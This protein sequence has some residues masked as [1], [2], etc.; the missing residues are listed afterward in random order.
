MA[1]QLGAK[2]VLCLIL[3]CLVL[4]PSVS[5]I[6]EYLEVP[7][8]S[9]PIARDSPE[10]IAA[11]KNHIAYI[12]GSQEA[13]M[14]GV[15]AY[16]ETISGSA[17]IGNLRQIESDYMAAASTIPAMKTADQI[18]S[19][20][21]EMCVQSGHFAEESKARLLLFN[22]SSDE[23]QKHIA[24]SINAFDL[25]LAG[26]TDPLWLSETTARVTVFGRESSERNFTLR[27]FQE[28][29][30]DISEARLISERID[31]IR[32]ALERAL[33][34]NKPESVLEINTKIKSLNQQYRNTVAGYRADR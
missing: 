13:R 6:V 21:D 25:S 28:N 27:H 34:D 10:N 18:N 12:G 14:D 1:K 23:M 11:L 26:M 15:I 22:G 29:G 30:I 33:Q 9:D 5:A 8:S 3:F 24:I 4:I 19:L 2:G 7:A 17:G 32:P 31:A 16:I 20:R